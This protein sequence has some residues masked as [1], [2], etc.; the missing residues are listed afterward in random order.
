MSSTQQWIFM[1]DLKH[2][3]SPFIL[4]SMTFSYSGIIQYRLLKHLQFSFPSSPTASCFVLSNEK[5][6]LRAICLRLKLTTQS[7]PADGAGLREWCEQEGRH[8]ELMKHTEGVC[9]FVLKIHWGEENSAPKIAE[10]IFSSTCFWFAFFRPSNRN[11]FSTNGWM[12]L[13]Q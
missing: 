7:R 2:H 4:N 6:R 5:K 13:V 12:C 11:Y 3:T 8:G 10:K 9:T 1:P